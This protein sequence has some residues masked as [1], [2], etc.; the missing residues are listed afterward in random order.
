MKKRKLLKGLSLVLGLVCLINTLT[1]LSFAAVKNYFDKDWQYTSDTRTAGYSMI[2]CYAY[3]YGVDDPDNYAIIIGESKG[4][5]VSAFETTVLAQYLDG[6]RHIQTASS[7]DTGT[8]RVSAQVSFY[9]GDL[10]GG[11]TGY[12]EHWST[13]K[14]DDSDYWCYNY[15][16]R[17]VNCEVGF[18]ET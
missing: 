6:V 11:A 7:D 3:D 17:F 2:D 13:S 1:I 16:V 12:T 15:V 18:V 9:E 8:A 4:G 14:T 5:A 10:I